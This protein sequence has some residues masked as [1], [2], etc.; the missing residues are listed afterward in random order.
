MP[1]NF[2][3]KFTG[4]NYV[5]LNIKPVEFHLIRLCNFCNIYM[6]N[7]VKFFEAPCTTPKGYSIVAIYIVWKLLN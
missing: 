1:L 5:Q 4:I 7:D 3:F 2:L 6:S